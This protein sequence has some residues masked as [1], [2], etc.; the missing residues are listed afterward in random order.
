MP[1]VSVEEA[2]ARLEDAAAAFDR[3]RRAWATATQA[4]AIETAIELESAE[5]DLLMARAQLQ[6]LQAASGAASRALEED[7]PGE[8]KAWGGH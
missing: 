5:R 1:V 7:E 3:A 2:R 6:A 8:E 4:H